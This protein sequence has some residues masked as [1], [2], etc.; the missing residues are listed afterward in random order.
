MK[1]KQLIESKER[2]VDERKRSL[3]AD[4]YGTST[5]TSS[6]SDTPQVSGL[7]FKW[8]DRARLSPSA[9]LRGAHRQ[10]TERMVRSCWLAQQRRWMQTEGKRR[11]GELEKEIL[12]AHEIGT[13]KKEI[14]RSQTRTSQDK[15]N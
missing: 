3:P 10:I 9:F 4:D 13:M 7:R 5:N 8:P 15:T 14:K 11:E 12:H 6:S 1:A 2:N